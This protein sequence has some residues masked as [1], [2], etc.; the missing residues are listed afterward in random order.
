MNHTSRREVLAGSLA[1]LG[2]GLLSGC[3][4]APRAEWSAPSSAREAPNPA[5]IGVL[6]LSQ[7]V[8]APVVLGLRQ[9]FAELGYAEG[10]DLIL[11]I[12]AGQGR[13][14]AA[15]EAA[16]ELV[17]GQVHVLVS[18]G[19]VATQAARDAAGDLPIVF[20]QV[21]DPV[22][23][24][25]VRGLAHPGG[26]L[27]GFS[28]LLPATT[29][30]R[31]E[32]LREMVPGVRVALMIYDPGNPTSSSSAD[33]AREAA[34]RLGVSLRERHIKNRD[35][36]LAALGEVRRDA[37]DALLL[38]PDSLVANAGQQIIEVAGK[39]QL[40][41][42]FHED[43]WV[44]RGGLA[45]YGASFRDLGRQAATYVDKLLKGARPGDLPVQQPTRFELVINARAAQALG[46]TIPQSVLMQADRIIQ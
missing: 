37:V 16:R 32:L 28:H 27:T 15:S 12:R 45:S 3:G 22:A 5:R 30:K 13:A 9:G 1:L 10:R 36:V 8:E 43:T 21:G 24:G 41:V 33:T 42:M 31:L 4:V 11:E 19:T 26:T 7:E 6:H 23:A 40:P 17:N 29:G 20:T 44:E 39:E 38:L 14:E 25:F 34:D 2:L 35:D 46:L 18:A